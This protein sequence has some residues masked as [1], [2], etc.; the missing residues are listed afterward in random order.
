MNA[1]LILSVLCLIAVSCT[2]H[3]DNKYDTA[4]SKYWVNTYMF[5]YA[6][7]RVLQPLPTLFSYSPS[8]LA[9]TSAQSYSSSSA[10][11]VSIG[12]TLT[13]ATA[14]PT[15]PTGI[16]FGSNWQIVPNKPTKSQ[17]A[18]KYTITGCNISGCLNTNVTVQIV[19]ATGTSVW[20][21]N[22]SFTT[23]SSTGSGSQSFSSPQGI[24]VDSSGGLY[25]A[26]S[27]NNRVLYFPA[28]TQTATR[29]YGQS[30]SFTSNTA[31]NGGI[32]ANSLQRPISVAVDSN[33]GVYIADAGNS[34]ILYFTSGSTT[35]S[36]VY[37]QG[38]SFTT[39]TVGG[40]ATASNFGATSIALDSNNNLYVVDNTRARVL[41]FPSGSTTATRVYG[42]NGSFTSTFANLNANTLDNLSQP[43]SVFVSSSGTVYIADYQSTGTIPS[44][45]LS[46]DSNQT[47]ASASLSVSTLTTFPIGIYVDSSGGVYVPIASTQTGIQA[48]NYYSS[49]KAT[50]VK[51]SFGSS[52]TTVTSESLSLPIA[53]TL[54]K[55][56][57]VY[58]S[59][60]TYN[61]VI[62][63]NQ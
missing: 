59:D 18:T 47:T 43:V 51:Y 37:G 24:A 31:N 23:S 63:Y 12:G 7:P 11:T 53:V 35:A 42:Q 55:S 33:N 6:I 41:F 38:G 9:F 44:R 21:Q 14:S 49:M 32:S 15:F 50:S 46:Y 28:N 58:I 3:L 1:K 52:E 57:N 25:V 17:A 4:T 27:S 48:V 40:S 22:G 62:K 61:R 56:G 10:N 16:G 8:D 2:R 20:G 60:Y 54:D 39:V 29:V 30:G 34:R 36:V 5:G 13:S 19:N 45:I 26:D